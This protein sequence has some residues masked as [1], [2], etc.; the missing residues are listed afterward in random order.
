MSKSNLKESIYI[1]DDDDHHRQSL[2]KLL[3][4]S[5]YI[6]YDFDSADSFLD[7]KN[8]S[9]PC[10]LLLDMRMP[11]KNGVYLQKKLI[12]SKNQMPIIFVSG[13]SFAEEI[14]ESMKNGAFDFVLKPFSCDT[15]LS[16]IARALELDSN[17]Q[18][19]NKQLHEVTRAFN[20]LTE[21]EKEVYY[22][23]NQGFPSITIAKK[24]NI[25]PRTVKAHKAQVMCKMDA[26]SLQSLL[27]KWLLI[28][29]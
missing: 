13:Q 25:T 20:N 4:L 9:H 19:S 7:F 6:V 11:E 14:I 15:L 23:L 28:H 12:E 27:K 5:G 10:A 29:E 1:V 8:I 26:D 22:H 16:T 17:N 21:R 18:A 2:K 24:L 3:S